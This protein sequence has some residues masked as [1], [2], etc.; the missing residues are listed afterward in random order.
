MEIHGGILQLLLHVFKELVAGML[1]AYAEKQLSKGYTAQNVSP[2]VLQRN[3][4]YHITTHQSCPYT[5][6][7]IN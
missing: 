7:K 1:R 2:P 5:K 4:A 6:N 3:M